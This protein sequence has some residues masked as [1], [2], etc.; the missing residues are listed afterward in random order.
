MKVGESLIALSSLRS[1]GQL[2][3][4][5][6]DRQLSP[7]VHGSYGDE[8]GSLFGSVFTHFAGFVPKLP[9]RESRRMNAALVEYPRDLFYPGLVSM[10]PDRAIRLAGAGSDEV[11][12]DSLLR[13]LFLA[14]E[15]AVVLCVY[16][17][18]RATARNPFEAALAAR[19]A[20]L[21]RRSLVDPETGGLYTPQRFV[22][23]GFA[24][25]SPH[26]AQNSAIL[27]EMAR[28]GLVAEESR[29]G[30]EVERK[31]GK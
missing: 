21:A 22:A 27:A 17:G 4:C 26:R 24:V 9:L 6:D 31:Q 20:C 5:G 2:V 11:E 10:T 13:D 29:E 12:D 16:D 7:V 14:P 3:L 1:G 28:L 19:L 30:D 8:A 23:E 15:D 18:V 25:L